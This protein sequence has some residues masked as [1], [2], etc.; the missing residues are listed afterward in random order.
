MTRRRAFLSAGEH[1][2]AVKRSDAEGVGRLV[3]RPAQE[4][5]PRG[6]HAEGAANRARPPAPGKQLRRIDAQTD[7][8][9]GFVAGD[10]RFEKS[11]TAAA[12][13]FRQRQEGGND[14]GA[15]AGRSAAMN[16]VEFA[17]MRRRR[18]RLHGIEI[19]SASNRS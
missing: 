1:A 6:G 19:R 12:M 16:V 11:P 13:F 7:T 2:A 17:A 10:R 14:H 9:R 4:F 18:H 3:D 15:D 5:R 8:R